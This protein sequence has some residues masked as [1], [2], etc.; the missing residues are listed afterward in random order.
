[1]K[2]DQESSGGQPEVVEYFTPAKPKPA[3]SAAIVA[4]VSAMVCVATLIV[5]PQTTV[6]FRVTL[7]IVILGAISALIFGIAGIW[8]ARSL[9]VGKIRSRIAVLIGGGIVGLAI[10]GV[11][12]RAISDRSQCGRNLG[13]VGSA[14]LLYADDHGGQFPSGLDVL[15]KDCQIPAEIFVSPTTN[16]Q[17]ATGPTTQQ[18]LADFA[19]PG[20]CSYV[21]L[22][23][24]QT[25]ATAR[26]HFVLAYEPLENHQ[27][28][29]AH[30]FIS[31]GNTE[32][33][34]ANEA[35]KIIEQLKNGV[36]PPKR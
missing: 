27:G 30:F 8:R 17:P 11:V 28:K 19:K 6:A 5:A 4:F 31:N 7:S 3:N 35:S 2:N 36:N 13:A 1:M 25:I 29:G 24:G 10:A 12:I 34:D 32:W 22:G 33:H 21:Y 18:L 23:A 16:D 20:H 9:G 26:N 15:V 14:L